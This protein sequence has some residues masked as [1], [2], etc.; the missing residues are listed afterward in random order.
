M[1]RILLLIFLI[2]FF[3]L[4]ACEYKDVMKSAKNDTEPGEWDTVLWDKATWKE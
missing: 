1:N 2:V 3:T 4:N